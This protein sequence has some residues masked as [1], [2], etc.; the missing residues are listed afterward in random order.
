MRTLSENINLFV[1]ALETGKI[2][3]IVWA[4]FRFR[5]EYKLILCLPIMYMYI[6]S[7]SYSDFLW[8]CEY[9]GSR[10]DPNQV[11]GGAQ[12]GIQLMF[13][14]YQRVCQCTLYTPLYTGM[15]VYT[16]KLCRQKQWRFWLFPILGACRAISVQL[17]FIAPG[18]TQRSRVAPHPTQR[19]S[20][21]KEGTRKLYT[22]Q[23]TAYVD[24]LRIRQ[25]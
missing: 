5:G 11:Q 3:S 9:S 13:N 14:G 6:V 16:G 19:F 18:P 24:R 2:A 21:H 15:C 17:V 7:G 22:G 23:I 12:R 1:Q 10:L 25:N 20:P 4:F 8:G